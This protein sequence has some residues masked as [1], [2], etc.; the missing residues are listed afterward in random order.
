LLATTCN[1]RRHHEL[2]ARPASPASLARR[3]KG[4]GG[5][6]VSLAKRPAATRTH[7]VARGRNGGVKAPHT[8]AR[9]PVRCAGLVPRRPSVRRRPPHQTI[10]LAALAMRGHRSAHSLATGPVMAEPARDGRERGAR[11][12]EPIALATPQNVSK[13]PS[14]PRRPRRRSRGQPALLQTA[15]SRARP[16]ERTPPPPQ[17]VLLSA[18]RYLST[19]RPGHRPARLRPPGPHPSSRPWG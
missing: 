10:E 19:S 4:Q 3:G 13:S 12:Q 6:A 9:L 16:P 1:H 7:A 2:L 18:R 8:G 14:A 11:R 15:G 5:A 17:H